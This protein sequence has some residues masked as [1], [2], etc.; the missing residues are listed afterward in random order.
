MDAAIRRVQSVEYIPWNEASPIGRVFISMEL[1]TIRG[2]MK[3]FHEFKKTK[4]ERVANAGLERG[5]IICIN[6]LNLPHPSIVAA[7]SR[8]FGIVRKN[9]L[10]INVP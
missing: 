2:H 1:V 9:C 3:L 8:S 4:V 5:I 10:N 6:I 7:S